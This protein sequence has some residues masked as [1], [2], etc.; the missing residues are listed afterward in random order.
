LLILLNNGV[1]KQYGN[2]KT[3]DWD[4]IANMVSKVVYTGGEGGGLGYNRKAPYIS[5]A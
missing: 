2:R 4:P 5:C 1:L 3:T